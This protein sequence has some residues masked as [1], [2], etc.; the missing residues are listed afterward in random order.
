MRTA[1]PP[2]GDQLPTEPSR[3]AQRRGIISPVLALFLQL[4]HPRRKTLLAG[5]AHC[6]RLR[7]HSP[8][9]P[10]FLFSRRVKGWSGHI[11][12]DTRDSA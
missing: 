1:S 8:G 10:A 5:T 4:S 3:A 7:C 11:G 12:V 9:D 2:A 6:S